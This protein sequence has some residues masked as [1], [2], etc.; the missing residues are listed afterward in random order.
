VSGD[1]G[2]DIEVTT[3]GNHG[4]A[5]G[6]MISQTNLASAVY[7]GLFLVKAI[8]SNTAYENMSA[9]FGSGKNRMPAEDTLTVYRGFIGAYP[10]VLLVVEESEVP[11][12]IA[13][14][15]ELA[16]EEDY[17]GLLDRYGIRRTDRD[18]W[19]YSDE[20][21]AAFKALDPVNYGLLDYNRLEN[22]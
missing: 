1:A 11:E 15:G 4:L 21:H 19:R 5:V 16:S 6:D 22:R 10:N 9:V 17:Q 12:F 20:F 3:T 18:F 14:V 8:I 2:V 7:T 13:A